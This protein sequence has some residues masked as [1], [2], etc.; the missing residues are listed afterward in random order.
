MISP[1]EKVQMKKEWN[2]RKKVGG[3][4]TWKGKVEVNIDRVRKIAQEMKKRSLGYKRKT[5]KQTKNPDV[6]RVKDDDKK[7]ECFKELILST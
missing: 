6:Y 5:N 3:T 1:R 4:P 2:S 7:G